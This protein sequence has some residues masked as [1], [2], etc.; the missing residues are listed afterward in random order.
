MFLSSLVIFLLLTAISVSVSVNAATVFQDLILTRKIVSPDGYEKSAV[1]INGELIG[2]TI[3]A[4][5][6]DTVVVNVT[7]MGEVFLLQFEICFSSF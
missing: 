4:F 2:P 1:V 6:G 3:E 5:F 7:N